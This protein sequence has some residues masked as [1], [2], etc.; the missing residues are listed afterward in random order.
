[1]TMD[2]ISTEALDRLTE[3]CRAA[4]Q[5]R[6]GGSLA[7][8][9]TWSHRLGEILRACRETRAAYSAL[10]TG[11]PPDFYGSGGPALERVG[12]WREYVALLAVAADPERSES[13]RSRAYSWSR[14]ARER[15]SRREVEALR[16]SWSDTPA[17]VA[18]LAE[19]VVA[20]APE[21]ARAVAP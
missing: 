4:H 18:A 2:E 16:E 17:D 19:R 6:G 9:G 13:D 15:R 12:I 8:P 11:T 5:A 21:H 14:V 10:R 7:E 20:V 3:E 1:M